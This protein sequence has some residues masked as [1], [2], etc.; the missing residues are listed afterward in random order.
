MDTLKCIKN[1]MMGKSKLKPILIGCAR[2]GVM[3]RA[4]ASQGFETY[5]C[6]LLDTQD[7]PK[8]HIKAD[9]RDI[10]NDS[11]WGMGIFHPTCTYLTISANWAYNDPDYKKYPDIGYHQKPK[12][13]TLVGSARREAREDALDMIRFL[14]NLDYPSAIENP[15]GS[16]SSRIRKPDQIIQ[17]WQ[18]GHGETKATCLWLN[19]LPKLQPTDI[20]DGR[21]QKVW[22]MAPNPDRWQ[23]R[24]KTYSGIAKAC[25]EQ[26]GDWYRNSIYSK[27]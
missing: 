3:R 5:E 10:A 11:R 4:F 13:D 26:W 25:A 12:A 21:E 7:D 23:E 15:I 1:G 17:P 16:I 22:K 27:E 20:V 8:Y 18:F 24:S 2:S 19:K 14:M 9:I 6:D